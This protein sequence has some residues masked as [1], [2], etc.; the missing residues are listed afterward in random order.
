MSSTHAEYFVVYLKLRSFGCAAGLLGLS[1]H[2][3]HSRL[4]SG[5]ASLV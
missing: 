2:H 5:F 1:V 4:L 3:V